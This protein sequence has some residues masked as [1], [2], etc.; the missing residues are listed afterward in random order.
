MPVCDEIIIVL[1]FMIY[2][3]VSVW[4]AVKRVSFMNNH[5][6]FITFT[7]SDR[8]RICWN[9]S[10]IQLYYK[11]NDC[12]AFNVLVLMELICVLKVRRRHINIHTRGDDAKSCGVVHA[13]R[14]SFF[15]KRSF[16][17]T[18]LSALSK[19]SSQEKWINLIFS[20]S[21]YNLL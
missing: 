16:R 20:Y 17:S 6:Y 21:N 2:W 18:I 10:R 3:P 1:V 11:S 14:C 19:V 5:M 7:G 4:A 15:L 8:P 9:S 12:S 13:G